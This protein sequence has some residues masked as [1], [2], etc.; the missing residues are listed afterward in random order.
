MVE[1]IPTNVDNGHM[2]VQDVHNRCS[3]GD[4]YGNGTEFSIECDNSIL[5]D[6]SI[7]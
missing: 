7:T 3:G 5:G 6:H 2:D 4:N 1:S